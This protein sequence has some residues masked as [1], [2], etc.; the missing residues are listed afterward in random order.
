MA[1]II[2]FVLGL[3]KLQMESVASVQRQRQHRQLWGAAHRVRPWA[4]P[5][6]HIPLEGMKLEC[7]M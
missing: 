5:A 1:E 7:E 3:L 4:G 6:Q 2:T